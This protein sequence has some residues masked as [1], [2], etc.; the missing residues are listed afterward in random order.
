MDEDEVLVNNGQKRRI[1]QCID[2]REYILQTDKKGYSSIFESEF[3]KSNLRVKQ[4]DNTGRVVPS[5]TLIKYILSESLKDTNPVFDPN[6][7]VGESKLFYSSPQNFSAYDSIEY[8]LD[9][10]VSS[11]IKDNSLLKFNRD[12]S[13]SF[14]SFSDYFALNRTGNSAGP[15]MQDFFAYEDNTSK[16]AN[17]TA[18]LN[19]V[20][21][22]IAAPIK[23]SFDNITNLSNLP[24]LPEFNFL[25]RTGI[26]GFAYLI[27]YGVCSYNLGDKNF[28]I[29]QEIGRAHV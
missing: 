7:D 23:F 28:F 12:G 18:P 8:L 5:G 17:T 29:Q 15:L 14:R 11:V 25:N 21:D 10:H 16:N 24:N 9:L 1:Y 4:L 22:K 19:K 13:F 26:D 3:A 27:S 6:W 2:V 20:E